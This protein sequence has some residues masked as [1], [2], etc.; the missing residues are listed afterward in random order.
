[1]SGRTMLI[2]GASSGIGRAL[3]LEYATSETHLFLVG[4]DSVR[5]ADIAELCQARGAT[6]VTG[7][8][9][10][11]DRE[12][13]ADWVAARDSEAPI[14]LAIACAGI[15]SGTSAQR[16]LDP[17][18]AMRA[19][20]A[21]DLMGAVNTI[22]P[23]LEAMRRR[24][25]GHVALVGSLAGLRG[26]PSSPAYSM[27]K[28]AIHAYAE[29]IRP[30][31]KR[32]GIAVSLIAPGFVTT[33]LNAELVAPQP[34]KL[35]AARAARI[36]RSGLDRRKPVIAFPFI[37]Y[38]GLRLLTLLPARFGDWLLD[39]PGVDVPLTQERERS[40]P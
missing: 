34:L 14:D 32:E 35:T 26:F 20:L 37:L 1:M 38:A 17:G 30:A 9:D 8:I 22:E 11:R 18:E 5:L 2:T 12:A 10:V 33:P 23:A 15:V 4:R 24:G 29:G 27:A 19:V 16:P 7:R 40:G 36:I 13:L 31:L 6:V 21:V 3:A 39:R 28:A 25:R